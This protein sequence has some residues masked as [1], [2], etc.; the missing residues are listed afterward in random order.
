[1]LLVVLLHL[2]SGLLCSWVAQP[3][4]P[5]LD[6]VPGTH[7]DNL[8]AVVESWVVSKERA[9]PSFMGSVQTE[10]L[11]R[12]SRVVQLLP[13]CTGVEASH[14]ASRWR[15]VS[16]WD[17]CHPALG[18]R[19]SSYPACSPRA[20]FRRLSVFL[21]DEGLLEGEQQDAGAQRLDS[22]QCCGAVGAAGLVGQSCSP[23]GDG[24]KV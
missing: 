7:L 8:L 22:L 16:H 6:T 14:S 21:G 13:G 20:V 19:C 10:H 3:G 4:S 1:M 17:R 9:V 12:S 2:C 23:W 18:V 11:L 5:Y 15:F 24:V